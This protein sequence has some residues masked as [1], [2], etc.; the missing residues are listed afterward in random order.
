MTSDIRLLPVYIS[1]AALLAC[2]KM[3]FLPS[4][5]RTASCKFSASGLLRSCCASSLAL[6]ANP[7]STCLQ[8][9]AMNMP[10][11]T[12]TC[13]S[14]TSKICSN[15]LENNP[16]KTLLVKGMK[17]KTM[18]HNL[19]TRILRSQKLCEQTGQRCS[20]CELLQQTKAIN[21]AGSLI[22][23]AGGTLLGSGP[24]KPQ[25]NVSANM[26]LQTNLPC[27]RQGWGANGPAVGVPVSGVSHL[28]CCIETSC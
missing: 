1:C 27:S 11:C 21:K 3:C 18:N 5:Y 2:C 16:S 19:R 15:T 7:S 20:Q 14:P 24:P 13:H 17:T 26:P 23:V 8:R 28:A 22:P 6:V 4:R 10:A 25:T 9:N 12:D